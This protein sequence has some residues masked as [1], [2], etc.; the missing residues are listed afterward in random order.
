ML[1]TTSI[2]NGLLKFSRIAS[3]SSLNTEIEIN[4]LISLRK[5]KILRQYCCN[6]NLLPKLAYSE[7]CNIA[8]SGNIAVILQLHQSEHILK[9][10]ILQLVTI[11]PQYCSSFDI[12]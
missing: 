4:A 7:S 6:M 11:L 8:A 1:G 10:A 2:I 5:I 3:G 12:M 9:A